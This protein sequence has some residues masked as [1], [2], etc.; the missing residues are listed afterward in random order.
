MITNMFSK[1]GS[2]DLTSLKEYLDSGKSDIKKNTNSIEYNYNVAPQI[3]SPNTKNIRQV[4]PDKSFAALGLGSS[5]N[6]NSMMSAMMSTDVFIRCLIIQVFI[7]INM[8]LKLESGQ[9][10]IMN[11]F[12]F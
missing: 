7:K 2:N 5:S 3:Y 6:S 9:K 4:H 11:V 12:W 8:I 10:A 1:I